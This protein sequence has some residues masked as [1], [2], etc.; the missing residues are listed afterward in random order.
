MSWNHIPEHLE[1]AARINAIN[2]RE[3]LR[4]GAVTAGIGLGAA[5]LLTPGQVMAALSNAQRM[6]VPTGDAMG[7]DH[8]VILMMENRSFDHYFGWIDDPR[9]DASITESYRDEEGTVHHTR[10]A[11]TILGEQEQWQGCSFRDPG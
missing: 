11:A 3:F 10:P 1:G 9:V 8:F 7:I 6:P 2:R 5:T 4:R